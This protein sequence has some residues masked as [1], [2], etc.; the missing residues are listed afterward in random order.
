MRNVSCLSDGN[1]YANDTIAQPSVFYRYDGVSWA[2]VDELADTNGRILEYTVTDDGRLWV[3]SE[4]FLREG[5]LYEFT[6][7]SLIE[8]TP[9]QVFDGAD[10]ERADH[11]TIV[12]P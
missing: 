3:L 4:G 1:A 9:D 6:D 5:P 7:G 10:P 2:V 8:H 12:A 11:L